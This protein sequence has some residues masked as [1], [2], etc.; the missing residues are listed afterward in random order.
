MTKRIQ[1]VLL[2]LALPAGLA[3][4]M[5]PAPVQAGAAGYCIG[6]M[7]PDGGVDWYCEGGMTAC[8]SA[9]DCNF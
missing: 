2:T 3:V 5:A 4:A 6:T 8:G 7:N 1:A 9:A